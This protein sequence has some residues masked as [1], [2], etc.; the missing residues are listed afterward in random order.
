MRPR[1]EI[2]EREKEKGRFWTLF[3]LTRVS[4][5]VFDLSTIALIE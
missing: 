5:Q 2:K 1:E 4:K 3:A